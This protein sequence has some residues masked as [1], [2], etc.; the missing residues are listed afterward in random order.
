MEHA[1]SIFERL[2]GSQWRNDRLY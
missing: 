2:A 1:D